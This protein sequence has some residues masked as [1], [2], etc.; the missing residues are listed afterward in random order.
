MSDTTRIDV[1]ALRRLIAENPDEVRHLLD[2][3]EPKVHDRY[4]R[5]IHKTDRVVMPSGEAGMVIRVDKKTGRVLIETHDGRTRLLRA[6][7]VEVSRGRPRKGS[8]RSLKT[9]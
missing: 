4:D 5:V 1:E 8:L 6:H 7:R 9:A 3:A 2:E